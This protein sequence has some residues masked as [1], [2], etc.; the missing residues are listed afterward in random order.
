MK[1]PLSA[2]MT[3][4]GILGTLIFAIYTYSGRINKTWGL[5]FL[6]FFIVI[7]VSSITS[8]G[9]GHSPKNKKKK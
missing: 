3:L 2:S 7:F 6:I 1:R 8:L 5:T 9:P 4:I